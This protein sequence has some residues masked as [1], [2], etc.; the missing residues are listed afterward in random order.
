MSHEDNVAFAFVLHCIA[1]QASG[2]GIC[3]S[4]RLGVG[5]EEYGGH[6]APHIHITEATQYNTETYYHGHI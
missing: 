2:V 5:G 6:D 4:T 1:F 3:M